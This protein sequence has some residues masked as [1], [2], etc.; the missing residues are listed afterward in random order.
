[1]SQVFFGID[2]QAQ[3]AQHMTWHYFI[4]LAVC[5]IE[6]PTAGIKNED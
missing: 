6:P 1:M 5:G 4:F 3:N 2:P